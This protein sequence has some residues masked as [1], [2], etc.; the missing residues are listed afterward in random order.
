MQASVPELTDIATEPDAH[1]RALRRRGE[2][3]GH[4]CQHR[5]CWPAGSSERGVRFVQIYHNNWDHH[6]NVAAAC[7]RQCKDVDQPAT[8]S[9][10]T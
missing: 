6:G 3:A 8:A 7:P 1:L 4:L 10:R 2:E 9:S 5:V